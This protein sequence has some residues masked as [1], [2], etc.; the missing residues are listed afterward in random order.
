MSVKK[1]IL[2]ISQRLKEIESSISH[3]PHTHFNLLKVLK[4]Y[5]EKYHV[6][7]F[8]DTKNRGKVCVF[9]KNNGEPV[10]FYSTHSLKVS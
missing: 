2:F 3:K 7:P 1:F 8:E 9:C 4:S 10:T 5:F 6:S